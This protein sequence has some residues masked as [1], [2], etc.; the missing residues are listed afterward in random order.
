M[1][2]RSKLQGF[3]AKGYLSREIGNKVCNYYSINT[4]TGLMPNNK[5]CQHSRA[6]CL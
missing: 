2:H 1:A 3:I 5:N 6:A 4:K